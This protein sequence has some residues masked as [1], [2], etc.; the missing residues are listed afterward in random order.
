MST[1]NEALQEH[2]S[3]SVSI[4]VTALEQT[5]TILRLLADPFDISLSRKVPKIDLNRDFKVIAEY[6][7]KD[8]MVRFDFFVDE[9]FIQLINPCTLNPEKVCAIARKQTETHG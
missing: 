9:S 5:L 4:N 3:H 6:S 7:T 1:T 8:R 2:P